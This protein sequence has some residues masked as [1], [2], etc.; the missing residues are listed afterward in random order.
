VTDHTA[1]RKNGG[2]GGT[3]SRAMRRKRK[4]ATASDIRETT[5]DGEGGQQDTSAE[6]RCEEGRGLMTEG[7][8]AASGGW[9][10]C[11]LCSAVREKNVK[12]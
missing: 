7:D 11:F 2:N 12:E 1:R 10:S 3:E 8:Q 4:K 5:L 9:V 6:V